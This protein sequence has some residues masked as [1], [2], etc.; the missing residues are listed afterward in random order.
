MPR[1]IARNAIIVSLI[2][3]MTTTLG[4]VAPSASIGETAAASP[5]VE[6]R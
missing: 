5:V 1:E 3:E 4:A 6:T 2:D